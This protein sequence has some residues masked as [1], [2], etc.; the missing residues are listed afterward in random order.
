MDWIFS[1]RQLEVMEILES[2]KY[3]DVSEI[4]YGGAAGGGK[5]FMICHW[6]I[7]RRLSFPKTR[8]FIGRVSLKNLM[9]T[10][11]NTFVDVWHRYYRNNPWGVTWKIN[12]S[13]N[14]ME[15]SNGSEILW[16]NLG[17]SR[18]DPEYHRL[19]SLEIT[20]AAIDE[21]PEMEERAFEV[22]QSRI[23][24]NLIN[25][26][27][28]IL[29]TGNPAI[30]WVKERY[31]KTIYGEDVELKPYQKFIKA[32]IMDNPD[33]DFKNTYISNLEKLSPNDRARLLHGEWDVHH[34]ENPF[35]YSF[36]RDKHYVN[37]TYEIKKQF[38]LDI[39]FDFNKDPCTAVVAQY[40]PD[41]PR[42]NII[43]SHY[44]S[45]DNQKSSLE[46]LCNQIKTVY[47]GQCNKFTIR[48]TGD[49]SGSAGGADI[50]SDVNRYT[51]IVKYMGLS[52]QCINVESSNLAHVSSRDLCNEVMHIIPKGHL[53]FY[54]GTETLIQNIEISYPDDKGTLNK[55]KDE[56]GLHDVD[57]FRYLLKFWFAYKLKGK[58]FKKYQITLENIKRRIDANRARKAQ[59]INDNN[60]EIVLQQ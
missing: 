22:I 11:F 35:F 37:H 39:S 18:E 20:D 9:M 2:E 38:P 48:I 59:R 52:K 32:T 51:R 50:P 49:A 36:Y 25:G 46:N 60:P 56:Y 53:V 44:A 33:E 23:R 6:Q 3:K 16:F 7:E 30:N 45:P 21:L 41:V 55:A 13:T 40:E 4:F 29:A 24:Y 8:G 26:A 27:P 57:C 5:S 17:R 28:K 15:F 47:Y 19:G 42:W 58:S 54:S 1:E 31:V 14:V 34:N 43:R 12:R 10:T